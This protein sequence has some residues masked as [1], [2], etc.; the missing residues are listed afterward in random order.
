MNRRF[1]FLK[2][3]LFMSNL[4]YIFISIKKLIKNKLIKKFN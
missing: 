3:N 4:G 1:I 2:N